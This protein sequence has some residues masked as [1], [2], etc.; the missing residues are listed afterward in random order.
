MAP[1]WAP[2]RPFGQHREANL[3]AS[4]VGRPAE[5]KD[6]VYLVPT[7][8]PPNCLPGAPAET[9]SFNATSAP[10]IVGTATRKLYN[11]TTSTLL[12]DQSYSINRDVAC[13]YGCSF[14]KSGCL[15][16]AQMMLDVS[17]MDRAP[18]GQ[19]R[20]GVRFPSLQNQPPGAIPQDIDYHLMFDT[21]TTPAATFGEVTGAI[22]LVAPFT[23]S[24]AV[25][26]NVDFIDRP[27]SDK[28]LC[29][30]NFSTTDCNGGD[31]VCTN[32]PSQDFQRCHFPY[33]ITN[34]WQ[35]YR[36]PTVILS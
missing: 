11:L 19:Q 2:N 36:K 18:A 30:Q 20:W 10:Q 9:Y 22:R 28:A 3:F 16:G 5:T 13:L 26:L 8:N 14:H 24:T 12:E 15:G 6:V 34:R 33:G 35:C 7:G 31:L 32:D 29:C 25:P 4:Y 27:T 1:S 17:L 21:T 23:S